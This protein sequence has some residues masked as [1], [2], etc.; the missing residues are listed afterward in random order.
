[1]NASQRP[2]LPLDSPPPLGYGV[3]FPPPGR[4]KPFG[5]KGFG[6]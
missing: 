4:G 1:M 6:A 2:G 3:T 5:S